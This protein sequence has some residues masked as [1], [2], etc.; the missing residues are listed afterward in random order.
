M[1][2]GTSNPDD[3]DFFGYKNIKFWESKYKKMQMTRFSG[4]FFI[5]GILVRY[6][7]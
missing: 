1:S 4:S 3:L 5:N 7:F 6:D 2:L